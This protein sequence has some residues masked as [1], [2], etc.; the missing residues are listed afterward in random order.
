MTKQRVALVHDWLTG[1]R[2]G[3]KVL[4]VLCDIFPSAD[5]FTLLHVRGKVSPTI[6]RHRIITSPLQKVPNIQR[7]Y[8]HLL[9]LMPWAIERLNLSGYDLVISTSH[10]VAKGIKKDK[11]AVHWSYCHTPMRYIWDQFDEYFGPGRSSAP[12][13]A[14]MRAVRPFLQQ[15]DVRTCE[16]VDHFLAN[17]RNVQER[18]ARIYKR[19]SAVIY[20]P[21]D[22]AFFSQ[23]AGPRPEA[24][25]YYLIVSAFAPYKR[26][27]YGL[28]TL[29]RL[30]KRVVV[31]GDGQDAARLKS[32]AGPKASFLGW[33]ENQELR[34]Y[35]A[36]CRALIFPG[37]EDF[38]IVPLEAMAAGAPVIAYGKGGALE[39]VVEGVTGLFFQEQKAAS[40]EDALRRFELMALERSNIQS[41]ASNFSRDRCEAQFRQTFVEYKNQMS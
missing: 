3:E 22:H 19:E 14:A 28:E 34:A 1:M 16:R 21:V 39:T 32:I 26:L 8:R 31:I 33:R 4:E 6:E 10:C 38:G 36:H 25:P 7:V 2:G 5:L 12:V 23:A 30:E 24:E 27:D 11:S 9:P 18:I 17:S 37:I 20:P 41:H 40:L 29:K 35:F 13:R 15:W